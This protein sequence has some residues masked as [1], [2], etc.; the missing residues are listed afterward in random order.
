M[1]PRT[2]KGEPA[3]PR[4]QFP[5]GRK[6]TPIRSGAWQPGP[7]FKTRG[8]ARA[9][10]RSSPRPAPSGAGC[11]TGLGVS[12]GARCRAPGSNRPGSGAGAGRPAR[13]SLL[14]PGATETGLGKSGGAAGARCPPRGA[15][16]GRQG[17]RGGCAR[18]RGHPS[19]RLPAARGRAAPPARPRAPLG[20]CTAPHK[21]AGGCG[22]APSRSHLAPA[23]PAARCRRRRSGQPRGAA[24]EAAA[25]GRPRRR[26]RAALEAPPRPA[27]AARGRAGRGE[28]ARGPPPAPG[29]CPAVPA[30]ARAGSARGPAG[31][32]GSRRPPRRAAGAA[33]GLC[34]GRAQP[35]PGG[36]GAGRAGGAGVLP[37]ARPR[38]AQPAPPSPPGTRAAVADSAR[39]RLVLPGAAPRPRTSPRRPGGAAPA[40]TCFFPGRRGPGGGCAPDSRGRRLRVTARPARPVPATAAP[41]PPS[42]LSSRPKNLWLSRTAERAVQASLHRPRRAIPQQGGERPCSARG[43]G[44]LQGREAAWRGPPPPFAAGS[45]TLVAEDRT[46]RAETKGCVCMAVK[47]RRCPRGHTMLLT[48]PFP[49]AGCCRPRPRQGHPGGGISAR[50]EQHPPPPAAMAS[51]GAIRHGGEIQ[52]S[53]S[54]PGLAGNALS[55][56]S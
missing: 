22:S 53:D 27:A 11:R 28:P 17:A 23:H 10:P 54:N 26:V 5:K 43:A 45:F 24:R 21:A 31:A 34:R 40:P 19:R 51:S 37:L 33:R 25:T 30:S 46:S 9:L 3:S 2:S 12:P 47:R 39:A 35:R 7:A 49:T 38:A 14:P 55:F 41:Q 36:L 20:A 42:G 32:L 8:K 56:V 44:R 50:T 52:G 48:D 4:T 16:G 18:T 6:E 29:K 15:A 13:L 1:K